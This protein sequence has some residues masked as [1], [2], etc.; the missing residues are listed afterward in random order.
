MKVYDVKC[1]TQ[2]AK[3]NINNKKCSF[4]IDQK[5]SF[6]VEMQES[7]IFEA[8]RYST[9]IRFMSDVC[10]MIHWDAIANQSN[11]VLWHASFH[12]I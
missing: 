7:N 4:Q 1:S 5:M 9:Y 3:H 6:T 10:F 2:F 8:K 11:F 12:L